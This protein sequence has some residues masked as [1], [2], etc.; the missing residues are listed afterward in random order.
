MSAT[1][2]A[3]VTVT[4]AGVV[5]TTPLACDA[6]NGNVLVNNPGGV[7][8][9]FKNTDASSHTVNFTQVGTDDGV[10]KPM[11]PCV[12]PA[13]ATWKFA[14]WPVTIYGTSLTFQADSALVQY[15]AYQLGT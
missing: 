15:S 2:I 9:E 11:K 14:P 7:L 8:L 13:N 1:P 5:N 12:I 3:L 4:R 10:T 6:A